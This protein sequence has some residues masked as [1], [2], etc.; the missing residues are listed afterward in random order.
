M[1]AGQLIYFEWPVAV[2]IRPSSDWPSCPTITRSST[3]PLLRGP[4]RSA[5]SCGSDCCPLRNRVT[6]SSQRSAGANL[7]VAVKLPSCTVE[8]KGG[9]DPV[10]VRL[11]VNLPYISF[12][13][14]RNDWGLEVFIPTRP[15]K[16]RPRK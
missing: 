5:Q 13:F 10:S 1:P 16:E 7:L 12:D 14:D 8:I 15:V 6:K 11:S 3:A 2:A 9:H 4:N